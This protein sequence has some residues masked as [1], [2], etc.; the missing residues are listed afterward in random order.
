[1]EGETPMV[2][3]N[4]R[5]RSLVLGGVALMAAVASQPA[6]ATPYIDVNSNWSTLL[7]NQSG[8]PESLPAGLS[9]TCTGTA[10][11][12]A[13]PFIGC[14]DALTVNHA[15]T[16]N[17]TSTVTHSG[18]IL[19]TNT[20]TTP[21][22]GVL[23]F[24]QNL[25]AFKPGGPM[26]GISIDYAG[27]S[28]S[29]S[30]SVDSAD[31]HSCSLPQPLGVPPDGTFY[32]SNG[33]QCGVRSPDESSN[34]AGQS[35]SLL[36]GQSQPVEGTSGGFFFVPDFLQISDAFFLPEPS[37]LAVVAPGLLALGLLYRRRARRGDM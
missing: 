33:L 9:L 18:G 24:Q 17:E 15:V 35:Y 21:L 6:A 26:V 30:S 16:S 36:P 28:A 19:L 13:S 12:M 31:F 1:M 8:R 25:S 29:Y 37:A 14:S 3:I 4:I 11:T 22:S 2:V 23:R 20:G 27:Q 10:V 7:V 5:N 34:G 32:S